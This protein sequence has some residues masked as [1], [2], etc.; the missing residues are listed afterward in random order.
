M[1]P[2]SEPT[3]AKEMRDYSRR[4]Y[5]EYSVLPSLVTLR[6]YAHSD[7][8]EFFKFAS[9]IRAGEGWF[10]DPNVVP[11]L[12]FYDLARS[13][14]LS[15]RAY[16][17]KEMQGLRG[18]AR[19]SDLTLETLTRVVGE[20]KERGHTPTAILLPIE[21]FQEAHLIWDPSFHLIRYGPRESIT[22]GGTE[23][24]LV[25]SNKFNPFDEGF[26]VS[27]SFARWVAKP[28]V[29]ER[30]QV[31]YES[32]DERITGVLMQTLFSLEVLHEDALAIIH[33]N[34][35]PEVQASR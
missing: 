7:T 6:D 22:I 8:G 9:H 31:T 25:W 12:V 16:L 34:E 14:G 23:M 19:T 35:T 1:M 5:A 10:T 30:L 27:S 17:V 32:D 33:R 2:H 28:S 21:V 4:T 29:E 18:A 15:E 11:D 26:V 24:R 13:I 3:K 20:L